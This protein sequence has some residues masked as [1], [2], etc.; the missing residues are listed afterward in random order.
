[1]DI[2]NHRNQSHNWENMVGMV[3]AL[4]SVSL[5][6]ERALEFRAV[7]LEVVECL[8]LLHLSRVR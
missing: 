3:A 5:G 1:M 4:I 2:Q 7:G 6:V 8:Q